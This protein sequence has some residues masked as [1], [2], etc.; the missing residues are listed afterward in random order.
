MRV[1]LDTRIL[2][3]ALLAP[4][5]LA[6]THR[7]IL[8]SSEHAVYFSA[9][10]VW[11]IAIKRALERP[12]FDLEPEAVR[13]EGLLTGFQELPITGIHAAAVRHLPSHHRDPFDRLLIAQAQ[14]EPLLLM[15]D[16]PQA[17]RCDV[18]R[19]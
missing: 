4:Q 14:T 13:R 19:I 3:W 8:E 12:D 1:L 11:E 2:L 5:R 9:V 18:G 16:D 15:S 6:A 10:N 17:A 7:E